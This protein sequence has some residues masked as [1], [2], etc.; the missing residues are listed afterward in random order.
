M[1]IDE[2]NA[3]SNNFKPFSVITPCPAYR[4]NNLLIS[5]MYGQRDERIDR[6]QTILINEL[7]RF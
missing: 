2:T 5:R 1:R 6:L 4:G 7:G 3:I